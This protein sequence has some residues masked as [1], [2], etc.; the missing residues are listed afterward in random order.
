M[1]AGPG[2]FVGIDTR[3]EVI[4]TEQHCEFGDPIH[5]PAKTETFYVTAV[6]NEWGL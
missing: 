1:K 2:W 6:A 5:Q 3:S 4:S